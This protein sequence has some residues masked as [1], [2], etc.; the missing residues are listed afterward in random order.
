M[1][2]PDPPWPIGFPSK[3]VASGA[4]DQRCE[5]SPRE[6]QLPASPPE[7]PGAKLGRFPLRRVVED[8]HTVDAGFHLPQ[9]QGFIH[10][11]RGF[12]FFS[13]ALS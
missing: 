1:G 3:H 5:A 6:V 8:A 9:V 2:T 13:R 11:Q 10:P 12:F 4:A 7:V